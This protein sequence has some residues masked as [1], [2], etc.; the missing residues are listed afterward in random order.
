MC[1]IAGIVALRPEAPA[2]A[3]EALERMAGSLRHRG[4]DEWGAYRDLRAGLAHARLSI[5]DL[6]G[7]QQPLSNED[8][9]LWIVFNGEIFNYVEIRERLVASGHR[10][11]TRSDTEVIVHAW[12]EWGPGCFQ[13][14]NGQWSLALWDARRRLLALS[15]DPF[16]ILP[17]YYAERD[18]RVYF[19]SEVKALFSG[20]PE[21]PRRLDPRGLVQSF[22]FWSTLAP[23]TVF[24]GIWELEPGRTRVYSEGPVVEHAHFE[25]HFP[26]KSERRAGSIED[27]VDAVRES[28]EKAASLRITRSDVP[29]GSYLS[30]GL[31]SSLI[32]ALGRR[33][34]GNRFATFSLRFEDAEY[35][36]TRFQRLVSERLSTDHRETVVTRRQIAETFPTAVWHAERPFLRTA[37]IPMFLLSRLVRD[38]GTKVVLTGEG[39]DEMF[40]GYDL[41]RE[42]RVRRFWARSPESP[43]R[44]RLLDRLYPYLARSPVAQAAMARRFFGR[45]LA[46]SGQVGFGHETRWRSTSALQRLFAP[47]LREAAQKQDV[48]GEFLASVPPQVARLTPLAQDQYLENRTLLS[49]YLLSVQGD[50]MLMGNSVEGRFPFLDPEIIR[51][52]NSLPDDHKLFGLDE[53]YVLKELGKGLVPD[54][55]LERSKQPYRAPDASAFVGS[56]LPGWAQECIR[57]ASLRESGVFSP[58]A[59]THLSRKLR[60]HPSGEP[61]SNA[62]NMAIVGVLSTEL[63]FKQFVATPPAPAGPVVWKVFEDRGG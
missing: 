5:I 7:G 40:A 51:L 4:P 36:E 8:G 60:E 17:L 23:R 21:L 39:A 61:F 18:G 13:R 30:G 47:A 63:L 37:P 52:A 28:L 1:G 38:S 42:A 14:F 44:P 15:R 34:A 16:G 45:N 54:E 25:Q 43:C 3:R 31:D 50:R 27:S 32:A 12:E 41:F 29:V 24:E 56:E 26:E 59:V 2:P 33:H 53:K 20:A 35:D 19:A 58:E 22:T 9:S 46:G 10:F 6:A 55:I 62:D 48:V 57:E 11:R 49:A